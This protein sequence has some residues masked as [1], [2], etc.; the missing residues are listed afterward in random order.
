MPVLSTTLTVII[1]FHQFYICPIVI[2]T[3]V[4]HMWLRRRSSFEVSCDLSPPSSPSIQDRVEVSHHNHL[5]LSTQGD[6]WCVFWLCVFRAVAQL[7]QASHQVVLVFSGMLNLS[8][9]GMHYGDV[10]MG[11]I[12]SQ[13]TSLTIVNSTVYSDADQRKHQ[14]SASLA[15]VWGIHRGSVNSS[16]KWPVTRKMFP[17]DDVIMN[18]ACHVVVIART[19]VRLFCCFFMQVTPVLLIIGAVICHHRKRAIACQN[20]AGIGPMLKASGP[21]GHVFRDPVATLFN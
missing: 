15:F 16:Q 4:N 18:R 11:A 14:S 9:E 7:P 5:L 21:S 6:G 1:H 17:F 2:V 19:T 3:M 20:R 13:I 12:A 8:M 10:I